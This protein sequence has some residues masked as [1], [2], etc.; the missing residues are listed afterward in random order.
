MKIMDGRLALG[1]AL[2]LSATLSA[3][4]NP[5]APPPGQR[6]LFLVDTSAAMKKIDASTRQAL[7]DLI[8]SGINGQMT[9]G[10]TFGIWTFNEQVYT[11]QFPMQTWHVDRVVPL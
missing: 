9:N 8:H 7:F 11:G 1:C 6:F 5:P 2:L 3:A 10:D 4:T